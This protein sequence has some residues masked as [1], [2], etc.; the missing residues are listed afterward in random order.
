[1]VLFDPSFYSR[2]LSNLILNA[3]QS[4]PEPSMVEVSFSIQDE[5]AIVRVKDDGPGIPGVIT[6]RIFEA[7]FTTKPSG[8]G[9]GLSIAKQGLEQG[10]GKIWVE[11]VQEGGACFSVALPKAP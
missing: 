1:M 2:V 8:S 11:S 6:D 9:L 3:F 7:R 10:G 4:K 5:Y